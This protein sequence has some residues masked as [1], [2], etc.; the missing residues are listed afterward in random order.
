MAASSRIHLRPLKALDLPQLDDLSS[1]QT[2]G[3]TPS[4]Q[5]FVAEVLQEGDKWMTTTLHDDNVFKTN[6]V[7]HES[8]ATAPIQI[9]S[10]VIANDPTENW[11]A[12]SK[13]W[14]R[15]VQMV[16]ADPS[17]KLVYTR[18]QQV[19]GLQAGKNSTRT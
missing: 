17:L 7:R 10:A 3:N 13:A 6:G 18:T 5:N 12:R 15:S 19:M 8:S 16:A 14:I 1:Q 9:R 11:F 4:L 2:Q